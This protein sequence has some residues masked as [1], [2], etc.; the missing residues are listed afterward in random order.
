MTKKI[1]EK[2]FKHLKLAGYLFASLA[3]IKLHFSEFGEIVIEGR[4]IRKIQVV[5]K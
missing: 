5:K 4:V 1:N 2:E 3:G